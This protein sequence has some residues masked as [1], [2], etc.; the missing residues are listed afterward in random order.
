MPDPFATV[1]GQEWFVDTDANLVITDQGVFPL[2][3]LAGAQ[4]ISVVAATETEV[5]QAVGIGLGVVFATEPESAQVVAPS[6]GQIIAVTA[7]TETEAVQNMGI[8]L[9]VVFATE[10]ESVETINAS[11]SVVI[12]VATETETAQAV[13][14]ILVSDDLFTGW[15]IPAGV[16]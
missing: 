16:S 10:P 7:V 15:G 12:G 4:S 1:Y 13:T 5:A 11:A 9:E 3:D 8:G 2:E 14:A 6:Q